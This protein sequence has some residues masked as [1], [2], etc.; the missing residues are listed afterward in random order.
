MYVPILEFLKQISSVLICYS[1]TLGHSQISCLFTASI[2]IDAFDFLCSA[3]LHPRY[4]MYHTGDTKHKI[5]YF[6]VDIFGGGKG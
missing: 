5:Q 6:I 4:L 2:I 1:I 3:F